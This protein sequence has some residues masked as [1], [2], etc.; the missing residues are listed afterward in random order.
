MGFVDPGYARDLAT[1][2]GAWPYKV[3]QIVVH[4]YDYKQEKKVV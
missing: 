3:A 2:S 4:E 1:R